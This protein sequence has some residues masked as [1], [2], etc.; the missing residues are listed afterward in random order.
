VGYY[1]RAEAALRRAL[2]INPKYVHTSALLA[3]VLFATHNFQG[4]LDLATP[5][6]D[7]SDA[8]QAL[9]TFGDAHL[10][11]GHYEEAQTAY[12]KLLAR[13]ASP[14]VYSRLAALADLRGEPDRALLLMQQAADLAR[15]AEDYG[16]SLAWYEF[17]M[18]ELYFRSGQIDKA[19]TH[20]QTAL[21][22]FDNYYLAL[23]GLGKIR[24]AQGNYDA[25]IEFYQHATSIIPQPEFLAALGD[26]YAVAGQQ[27]EA[28][29]Q[30]ETVE[31]IGKLAEINQQI[32]N[33]QLANF[34]VDH[35]LHPAEA[36]TLATTE[37]ESRQDIYGYDTAAWA[38]Y[39]NGQFDQAQQMIEQAMRLGTREAKLYYHAGMI[40]QAQGR[41]AEAEDLLAEAL[42]INPHFDLL[43]APFAQDMLDQ[44]RAK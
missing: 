26:I 3:S 21:E 8:L 29:R 2:E 37:L 30:Y 1:Q 42:T 5:L 40:A 14:A 27:D 6:V 33:R 31:Y 22:V 36:L 25:A 12:E 18:G 10:A 20:F 39:K 15:Q 34:Y 43:Q 4:A 35:D 11:L 7:H 16:E 23:A 13:S 24:A 19:E 41:A 9:A 44:L 38:Y 17:Q 28:Q 32:Y